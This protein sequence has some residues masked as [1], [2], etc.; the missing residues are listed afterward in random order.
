MD[1]VTV[2]AMPRISSLAGSMEPDLK[3]SRAAADG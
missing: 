2:G 3:T 1:L